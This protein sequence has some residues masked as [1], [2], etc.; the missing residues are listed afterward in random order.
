[1]LEQ[2]LAQQIQDHLNVI[3]DNAS[4]MLVEEF[5]AKLTLK[6]V[7]YLDRMQGCETVEEFISI[8]KEV[9]VD[10][11]TGLDPLLI[12]RSL[13]PILRDRIKDCGS[14]LC[15]IL[16]DHYSDPSYDLD[17]LCEHRKD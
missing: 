4:I 3:Y 9:L 17:V 6:T 7:K 11:Y 15:R 5:E 14:T 13:T 8:V 1:M 12:D 10:D 2:K 16:E